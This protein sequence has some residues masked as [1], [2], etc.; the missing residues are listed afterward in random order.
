MYELVQVTRRVHSNV[1]SRGTIC[2]TSLT[3]GLRHD[4]FQTFRIVT[5]NFSMYSLKTAGQ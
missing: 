5:F 2:A 4:F 3:N 1:K